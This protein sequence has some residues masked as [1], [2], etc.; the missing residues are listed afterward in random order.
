MKP[1]YFV[2]F[3]ALVGSDSV[4]DLD[5][6]L[7]MITM[8]IKAEERLYYLN[9]NLNRRLDCFEIRYGKYSKSTLLKRM[10]LKIIQ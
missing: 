1:R 7:S 10:E 9:K 3:P 4:C 6:R 5:G 8:T 2:E